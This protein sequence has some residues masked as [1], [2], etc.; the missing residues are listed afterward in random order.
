M[1]KR[2]IPKDETGEW[3]NPLKSGEVQPFLGSIEFPIEPDTSEWVFRP[4]GIG[5]HVGNRIGILD[6][7]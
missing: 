5:I 7:I 1:Y 6:P 4:F 2:L 3:A